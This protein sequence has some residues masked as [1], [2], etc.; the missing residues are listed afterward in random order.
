MKTAKPLFTAFVITFAA[1][2]HANAQSWLT[3]G[4]IAYYPFNG[5]ANDESG[6]GNNGTVTAATLALDRFGIANAAYAFD[7]ASSMITAPDSP[8]LRIPGDITVACWVN[9]ASTPS[10]GTRFV[11]KGIG[12]GRNYGLWLDKPGAQIYWMFQ[13]FP[14]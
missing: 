9:L 14:P 12:C 10:R 5:N 13:Q 1:L 11:G 2:L 7:G 3:N 8:S 6:N 4:L